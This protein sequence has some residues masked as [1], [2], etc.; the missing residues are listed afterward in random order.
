MRTLEKRFGDKVIRIQVDS[1]NPEVV[2]YAQNQLDTYEEREEQKRLNTI[3]RGRIE[4]LLIELKAIDQNIL[5]AAKHYAPFG[6]QPFVDSYSALITATLLHGGVV[7]GL[8]NQK[9][10][11]LIHELRRSVPIDLYEEKKRIEQELEFLR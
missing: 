8:I 10:L 6:F 1:D 11:S 5:N 2:A 7:L 9:E 4:L 3:R